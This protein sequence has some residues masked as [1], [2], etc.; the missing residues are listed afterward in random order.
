MPVND[1]PLRLPSY[2]IV[3]GMRM[4]LGFPAEGLGSGLRYQPSGS[5]IFVASYPKCGTTWLQYIV[6]LL[7]RGRPL[8]GNE[9]LAE[10]FPHLEEVGADVVAALPDPRL[11][12]THLDFGRTPYSAAARY[13]VILRNPFDC[14]VSFFHHTTGFP[15]HYD[16]AG[17]S[18]AAFF[19]C[20]I[21]GEVDFGGY[22]DH[23]LSWHEARTRPNVHFFT[24]EGMLADPRAAVRQIA[25]VLGERAQA[26]VA[27][28]PD[29]E[30]V[31]RETSFEAMRR[32]PLR[33][34]SERPAWA[35][36]F[37]RSGKVGDWQSLFT[38][39]QLRALLAEFDRRLAGTTLAELWP[40]VLAKARA[41]A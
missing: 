30:A 5:D 17:G 6:W 35:T 19:D 26:A 29:L 16:F 11:I 12:K 3:N 36:G 23:L 1:S 9:S 13:L 32:D 7:I 2:R 27:A 37:V 28:D 34:S 4:P 10:L 20:F 18:F 8:A 21:R 39:D 41:Q 31:I 22:F 33:W 25:A 24:Y 38:R 40:D 14:A 15:R